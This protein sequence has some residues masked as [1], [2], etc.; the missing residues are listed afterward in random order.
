MKIGTYI[1]HDTSMDVCYR[2]KNAFKTQDNW[3]LKVQVYNMGFKRSWIIDESIVISIPIGNVTQ[4]KWA[5]TPVKCM[6]RAT[7]LKVLK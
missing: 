2:I 7:W 5:W 1:K 4:W 3:H 6:R